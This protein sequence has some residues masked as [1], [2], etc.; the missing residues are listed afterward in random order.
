[1]QINYF[2]I[3]AVQGPRMFTEAVEGN[4]LVSAGLCAKSN[5]SP[6]LSEPVPF[7]DVANGTRQKKDGNYL[8]YH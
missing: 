2:K 8:L 1:M 4:R 5:P 3:T 7:A 6:F